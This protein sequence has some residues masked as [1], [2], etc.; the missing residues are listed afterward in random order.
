MYES[1]MLL[2]LPYLHFAPPPVRRGSAAP[3]R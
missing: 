1:D 2:S 3:G